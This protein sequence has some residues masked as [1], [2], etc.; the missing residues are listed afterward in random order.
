MR[1]LCA[2]SRSPAE[3][4]PLWQRTQATAWLGL[5]LRLFGW[6]SA[7]VPGVRHGAETGIEGAEPHHSGYERSP[8]TGVS[9]LGRGD[10]FSEEGG[11]SATGW[12]TE[13][14]YPVTPDK[15]TRNTA[16]TIVPQRAL[17]NS[18]GFGKTPDR[19]RGSTTLE[20]SEISRERKDAILTQLSRFPREVAF[21]NRRAADFR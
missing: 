12:P 7:Q 19:V 10:I 5:C 21:R 13:P 1:P 4:S 3:G 11:G 17:F 6:Q 8:L 18:G 20:H 15:N 16:T 14:E 2:A 9:V